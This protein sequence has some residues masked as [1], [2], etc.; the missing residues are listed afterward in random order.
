[1]PTLD[2]SDAW[3]CPEMSDFPSF[4]VIRRAETINGVGRSE[5]TPTLIPNLVGAIY[6]T[7]DNSLV[8]TED[9]QLSRKTITVVTTFRLMETA[10][11]YQPDLVFWH[12]DSF[13]VRDLNDYSAWGSGFVEA[14]C[15]SIDL[16]DLP[17]AVRLLA[18]SLVY[19]PPV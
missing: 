4:D 5:V 17:P 8:R 2:V 10:P 7:G 16:Q 14:E 15:T 18:N 13:I 9:Y 11:G 3:L 1:M 19:A 12:G 6:P